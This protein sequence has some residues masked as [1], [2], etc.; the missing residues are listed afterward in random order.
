M[1]GIKKNFFVA[2][3]SQRILEYL[4]MWRFNIFLAKN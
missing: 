4:K 1:L 2:N 3:L